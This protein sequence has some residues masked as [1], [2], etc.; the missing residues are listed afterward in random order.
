MAAHTSSG[1]V[2]A[3]PI[4]LPVSPGA[5]YIPAARK[6]HSPRNK[7]HLARMG[8]SLKYFKGYTQVEAARAVISVRILGKICTFSAARLKQRRNPYAVKTDI[9]SSR[10]GNKK[11][12]FNA[13]LRQ[14]LAAASKR[15][16]DCG[17]HVHVQYTYH[18]IIP[19]GR[20]LTEQGSL[21]HGLQQSNGGVVHP[22][23]DHIKGSQHAWL[24]ARHASVICECIF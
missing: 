16:R 10:I 24:P 20:D 7:R 14:L 23:W 1:G 11:L 4:P 5:G 12:G 8:S 17:L 2:R 15:N 6:S 21:L 13:Q 3:K 18:Q 22:V 9:K 19:K